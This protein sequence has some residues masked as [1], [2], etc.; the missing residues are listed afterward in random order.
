MPS[1]GY[2]AARFDCAYA[3]AERSHFHDASVSNLRANPSAALPTAILRSACAG[4]Q[5]S[6]AVCPQ[7]VGAQRT[8]R[9]SYGWTALHIAAINN[10]D[11]MVIELEAAGGQ[12]PGA[13]PRGSGLGGARGGRGDRQDRNQGDPDAHAASDLCRRR[14]GP[15]DEGRSAL[16]RHAL[17]RPVR[18]PA[19]AAMCTWTD[20]PVTAGHAWLFHNAPTV[21]ECVI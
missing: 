8:R 1:N 15:V 2:Q 19:G 4:Q 9:D 10:F 17:R 21:S 3:G 13:P 11:D 5:M 18:Q 16:D 12:S 6:T 20:R 7:H 14:P